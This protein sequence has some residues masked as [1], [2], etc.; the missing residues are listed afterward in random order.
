MLQ[1]E[2]V[3]DCRVCRIKK[4]LLDRE[5][6]AGFLAVIWWMQHLSGGLILKKCPYLL[7]I[8]GHLNVPRLHCLC[9]VEAA[10]LVLLHK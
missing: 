3:P 8:S 6:A 9:G 7:L 2:L 4:H 5:R 10:H 1:K